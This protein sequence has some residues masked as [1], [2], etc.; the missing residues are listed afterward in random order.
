MLADRMVGTLGNPAPLQGRKKSKKLMN[1][2]EQK[3]KEKSEALNGL[4]EL[5]YEDKAAFKKYLHSQ[6]INQQA[7]LFAFFQCNDSEFYKE[8][9]E[10]TGGI[11]FGV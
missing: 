10:Y 2:L 1:E 11:S 6:P 9:N 7:R 8:I 3:Y 4:K 5:F